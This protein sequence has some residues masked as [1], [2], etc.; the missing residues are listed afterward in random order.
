MSHYVIRQGQ[1]IAVKTIDTGIPAKAKP[2]PK[3]EPFAL[4]PLD[5]AARAAKATNSPALVICIHLLHLAWKTENKTVTLSNAHLGGISVK[6]KSRIL[7]NLK[8]AGLVEVEYQNG[9]SP[10]VTLLGPLL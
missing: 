10:R 6:V 8:A 4:I 3:R 1:R 5:W 7:R 2:Q 9:K